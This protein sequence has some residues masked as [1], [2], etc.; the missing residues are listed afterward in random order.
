[1][2]HATFFLIILVHFLLIIS[3]PCSAS[4]QILSPKFPAI[5]VFGDST[6]DSGNNN[7][8][9]TPFRSDHHP[10]GRDFKGH[11]PT[12]RCSN[13]KLVTDFIASKLE[14][15]DTVPPFLH[16]K[17]SDKDLV[18]GVSF[19]SAGSG[20][21]DMTSAMFKIIPVLKQVHYFKKYLERL[22]EIV[23]EEQAKV[24]VELWLWSVLG[25]MT[26][27]LVST[28]YQLGGYSLA[29]V[30]IKICC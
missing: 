28:T 20:L 9:N 5:L 13:G 4:S 8:I 23:G 30:S 6:V 25:V 12:G 19:A 11:V 7:Y 21:D 14:I 26:S 1:M 24:I 16:P 27:L 18:T 29:L 10:Y 17:L 22:E 3:Y 15:K 2:A